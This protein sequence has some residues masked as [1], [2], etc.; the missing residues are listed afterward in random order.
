VTRHL[1][2]RQSRTVASLFAVAIA[3]AVFG[4]QL[5]GAGGSISETPSERLARAPAPPS[6]LTV[7]PDHATLLF[8]GFMLLN[9]TA[10]IKANALKPGIVAPAGRGA[11]QVPDFESIGL[12]KPEFVGV[13]GTANP[14]GRRAFSTRIR[15]PLGVWF[16]LANPVLSSISRSEMDEAMALWPSQ[17][18]CGG[19]LRVGNIQVILFNQAG[20][21]VSITWLDKEMYRWSVMAPPASAISEGD[22]TGWATKIIGAQQG[23]G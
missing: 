14:D 17:C 5:F 13:A 20:R 8:D 18:A 23:S 11:P 1:R 6:P 2:L 3:G 9:T 16:V 21:P 12:S 4:V 22:L 19:V 10:D 15:T 7:D